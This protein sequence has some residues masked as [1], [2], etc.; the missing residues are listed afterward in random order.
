MRSPSQTSSRRLA[1]AGCLLLAGCSAC[2]T[3][4]TAPTPAVSVDE[5]SQAV[6]TAPAAQGQP[7]AHVLVAASP[8]ALVQWTQATDQQ[9]DDGLGIMDQAVFGQRVFVRVAMA[10][11]ASEE[12]FELQGTLRLVAPDGR[13]LHEQAIQADQ[14]DLDPEAPGVLVLMP[15][16]DIVFDPG[17]LVGAY[18][19]YGVVH[20]GQQEHEA[21]RELRVAGQGLQLDP[22]MAL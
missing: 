18:H 12:P 2:G 9:R 1:L 8:Q 7:T 22:A 20:T 14:D 5:L 19:V 21:H 11:L 16:M 10:G 15:G 3:K 13:T 6:A 17:D 4:A